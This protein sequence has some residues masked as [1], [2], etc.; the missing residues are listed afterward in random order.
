MPHPDIDE[1]ERHRHDLLGELAAIGP[2]R[3]GRLVDKR[4][5][6][7]KPTCRYGGR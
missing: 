2:F 7:G 6:C 1:L 3:P 5:K 4:G